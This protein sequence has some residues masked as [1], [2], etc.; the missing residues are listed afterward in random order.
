MILGGDAHRWAR[1]VTGRAAELIGHHDYGIDRAICTKL[2]ACSAPSLTSC[3]DRITLHQYD[4]GR[5]GHR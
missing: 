5:R 3:N 2:S 4:M 1:Q